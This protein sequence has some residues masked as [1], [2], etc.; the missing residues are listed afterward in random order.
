[1]LRFLT[2]RDDAVLIECDD[3]DRT[4]ALR[5]ALADA[6]LDGVGEM[7]PGARTLLVPYRPAA[8]TAREIERTAR[9]A[10]LSTASTV[11]PRRLEIPVRYDGEDL[12]EVAAH[13]GMSAG[14]LVRR[15]TAA[16][17]TVGFVGFAPG[18]AY[19]VGDDPGIDVPRRSTPRTRI[20]AGSVALAGTYS[21]VYPRESPGGW[22]LIGT[23]E[24]PMWDLARERPAFLAPGDVVRFTEA[25]DPER[26]TV[27]AAADARTAPLEASADSALVVVAPGIQST[28][29]DLGRTGHAGMGVSSS[30]A[31][32]APAL[33]RANRLV[34]NPAG[35]AAVEVGY[36][37][38]HLRATGPQV[39]AVTGA[40]VAL[41]VSG[42]VG[43]RE[44]PMDAPFALDD[45][46]ELRLGT[47]TSG[48]RSY[49]AVRGG[50]DVL[51][52]LGSLATDVLAG[53]GP[54]PLGPGDV[55][56]VLP[57]S[58]G[59]APVGAPDPSDRP[60]PSGTGDVVP[61]DIVLGPRDD[62]FDPGQIDRL[63]GQDW[64]VSPRSNRVGVRLDGV[65]LERS[66]T[67]EL[68]SEG[69]VA[70]ALQIPPDGLPVLFLADHPLTGGYPVV[71]AVV[72]RDLP[73]AG[74]LP[75]GAR[76]R[77]RVVDPAQHPS[78]DDTQEQEAAS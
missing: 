18:F 21:G 4:I 36:G 9:A 54:A 8:I 40:A 65:A 63:T 46:E 19:L 71:G 75:V 76:V 14:E 61:L 48:V 62:W 49:V 70:G 67:G 64:T 11:E 41:T 17:Y 44:V 57:V 50:P 13:L 23:T 7:I 53:L 1:V 30:G 45:G 77:F 42:T 51:P 26:E 15:H 38:L 28:L 16:E 52:V 22:Q 47:A 31:L 29:Q 78:P 5:D 73:T 56:P 3:L 60:L 43:V 27:R 10:D 72:A 2:A 34:G 66:R 68:P 69:C 24:V 33:R 59:Q 32:D 12:A 25:A 37:G 35:T 6:D 58:S 39:L 20:P 74:Q 55:L